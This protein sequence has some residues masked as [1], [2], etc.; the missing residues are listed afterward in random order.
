MLDDVLYYAC[1]FGSKA[2]RGDATA[3][4]GVTAALDPLTGRTR[5]LTTDHWV[6]S[7]C[8]IS[9]A[10]GRLYVGGYCRDPETR[11]GHIWCLSAK[12]GSLVWRSDPLPSSIAVVTVGPQL[13]FA[14]SHGRKSHL[15]DKQT[16]R[17]L[18]T[19]NEGYKCSRFTLA[20]SYLLGPNLDITELSNPRDV[21]LLGTGPRLDPSE[22]IG[23]I[24]SNG[25][26]FY[27]CHAGGLQASLISAM[28]GAAPRIFP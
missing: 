22:C 28:A 17:I 2:R 12:D 13:L 25:R 11:A 7:G 16:G 27:T 15:L 9:G 19:L 4:R 20:G 8:S 23:G 26:V 21:R 1:F 24:A 18:N 10:E 5:W 3:P 6:H 14:H